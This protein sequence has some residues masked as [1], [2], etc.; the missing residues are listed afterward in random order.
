VT[1]S[2][3]GRGTVNPT[4][5][6]PSR[7]ASVMPQLRV[8]PKP[9]TCC[10]CGEPFADTDTVVWLNDDEGRHDWDC[11]A[12]EPRGPVSDGT[13]RCPERRDS[14]PC[15]K[16]IPAGWHENEGHPGGH[17]FEPDEH[18]TARRAGLLHTDHLAAL[19]LL[20]FEEHHAG[21]CPGPGSC[22]HAP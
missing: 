21:D 1:A 12:W 22:R 6:H 10:H 5:V 9:L 3:P 14:G 2:V 19:S 16:T 15:Q 11:P 7:K 8:L 20:T 18:A 13:L 17:W 4:P